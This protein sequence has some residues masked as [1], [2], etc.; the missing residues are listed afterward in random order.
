MTA[1][2]TLRKEEENKINATEMLF[3]RRL[4]RASYTERRTSDSI[5]KELKTEPMLLKLMFKRNIRYIGHS[6]R[7]EKC[8]QMKTAVQ[9]KMNGKNRREDLQ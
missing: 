7:N 5:L 2:G 3:Y 4:L 8:S 9:G 6:I 1:C